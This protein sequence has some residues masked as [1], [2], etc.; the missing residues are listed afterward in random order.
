MFGEGKDRTLHFYLEQHTHTHTHTHTQSTYSYT[1][2]TYSTSAAVL[3]TEKTQTDKH[4]QSH[5]VNLPDY[6]QTPHTLKGVLSD[7]ITAQVDGG[8]CYVGCEVH[9]LTGGD[10]CPSLSNYQSLVKFLYKC[11]GKKL[12]NFQNIC[13]RK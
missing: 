5:T 6:L 12:F 10:K 13:K 11:G 3:M 7:W 9:V 1:Y 8:W 4:C 2:C